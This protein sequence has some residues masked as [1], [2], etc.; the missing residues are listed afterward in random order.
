MLEDGATVTP[1]TLRALGIGGK[2]GRFKI[3]GDGDFSAK[4][5]VT[6]HAFSKSAIQKIEAAGGSATTV[7]GDASSDAAASDDDTPADA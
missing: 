7:D 3:L 6:A 2:N 4:L 5:N 1:D